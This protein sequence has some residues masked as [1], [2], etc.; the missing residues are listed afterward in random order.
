MG[1]SKNVQRKRPRSWCS[2]FLGW[3]LLPYPTRRPVGYGVI[4]LRGPIRRHDPLDVALNMKR[5]AAKL[6][7]YEVRGMMRVVRLR[8]SKR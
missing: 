1:Q 2:R 3:S 5:N 8:L 6:R 4:V 7:G